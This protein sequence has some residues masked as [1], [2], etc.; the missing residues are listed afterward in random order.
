MLMLC[1]EVY[2]LAVQ[3]HELYGRL[4]PGQSASPRTYH[5]QEFARLYRAICLV[6][7]FDYYIIDAVCQTAVFLVF[8][9]ELEPSVFIAF[10]GR[11]AYPEVAFLSATLVRRILVEVDIVGVEFAFAVRSVLIIVNAGLLE[12]DEVIIS[13]HRRIAVGRLEPRENR[14]GVI[15]LDYYVAA[16]FITLSCMRR[17]FA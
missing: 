12:V 13:E 5:E 7:N 11:D 14:T 4:P 3:R 6:W 16:I 2:G 9:L 17:D 15:Y 10:S 1:E 8:A